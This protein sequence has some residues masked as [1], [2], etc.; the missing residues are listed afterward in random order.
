MISARSRKVS[1]TLSETLGTFPTWGPYVEILITECAFRDVFHHVSF[2]FYFPTQCVPDTRGV[3]QCRFSYSFLFRKRADI[4]SLE[5]EIPR[6]R[7][8]SII[9]CK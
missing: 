9:I 2:S 7:S 1:C 6:S 5:A 4:C 3:R 8:A